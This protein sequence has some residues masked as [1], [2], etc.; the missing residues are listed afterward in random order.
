MIPWSSFPK[1]LIARIES[2]RHSGLFM[3]EDAI[4]HQMRLVIGKEEH[5][6]RGWMLSFYW[7]VDAED[8]VIADSKF[9]AFGPP[10][11]IGAADAACELVIRKNYDQAS[12]ISAE[13][14]DR[15]VQNAN[16]EGAFPSMYNSLL[17]GVLSALENAAGQC[18]DIPLSP[19]YVA[20]PM[21]PFAIEG[22]GY[23]GWQ[24]LS[25][26]QKMS[27]IEEIVTKE[28]QPYIELDAGGVKVLRLVADREVVIAYSGSCTTCHSATGTTLNAIQQILRAKVSRDLIVT[29]DFSHLMES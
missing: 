29:P 19:H 27:V 7:L 12:R 28:I 23:P 1:K 2:P 3:P 14:I 22:D 9:Q 11:L 5:L 4:A 13:L 24:E 17:N 6:E 15:Q 18:I 20:T 10:A 25:P 8:G 16:G 21:Q 26:E